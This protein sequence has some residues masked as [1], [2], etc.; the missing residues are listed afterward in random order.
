MTNRYGENQG[1]KS[2]FTPI[3]LSGGVALLFLGL[4]VF[5]PIA[6][7]GL[8]LIA[9]A[10]FQMYS[11]GKKEKYTEPKEPLEE[12]WPLETV[13]KEKLGT[14]IFLMSEILIFGALIIAYAYVRADSSSWIVSIQVH[15]LYLGTGNTII[16]LTSGLAMAL[17]LYSI[18]SNNSRGLKI[19]LVSAFALGL[20]FDIIK[21]GA[22]WPGLISS[23]FTIASGLPGSTYFALTGLHAAHVAAG[24]V[25][26]GYLMFR[27]FSG[28]FSSMKYT[29]VESVGLYWAF[30]D[31][32]WMF[33]FPLFYLI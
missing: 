4:V 32:V 5:W 10:T 16:L 12:K 9:I 11:D 2:S 20:V 30:V 26:I 15:N 29:A 3:V 25:A 6:L 7:L 21:L 17:A 14:W 13:S 1:R 27:A 24:L 28:G 33:L 8:A 18:K 23:G 22:E 31:I 19:G